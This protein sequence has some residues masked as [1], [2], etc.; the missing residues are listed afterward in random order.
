[1]KRRILALFLAFTLFLCAIPAAFAADY[2]PEAQY[3]ILLELDE[4]IRE[5]GLESSEEDEPLERALTRHLK[6]IPGES[7]LIQALA[8]DPTLFET[9]M[10]TM[11]SGYDEHTMYLPAGTYSAA[12]DPDT[13]YVGI[14]VTIQAHPQGVLVTDVNLLGSAAKAGIQM[15]D[16][17]TKADGQ[18]LAGMDVDAA[19]QLLRGEAGTTVS[20]TILRDG[21]EQSFL[22]E[23]T[24]LVQL[25]YSGAPIQEDIFYMK[26]SRIS[27]DGSYL[28]FRM[29]LA[30]MVRDGYDCLILDLRDNPG[31]SL[32]LAFSIATDLMPESGAFFRI[33]YRDPHGKEELTQ[34]YIIAEGDGFDV[35]YIFIL[36]NGNSA[37]AS[38]I[39]TAGLRDKEGAVVIGETTYGKGRAQQ[40]YVL[41]NDAGI[42]LTTMM[43][44][45]LEGEDYEG[46]GL[47]PDV[48]VHNTVLKGENAITVPTDVALAPYSCS[49]NGEALNRALVSLGL[50]EELPEKP[51]QVGEE[52]ME[53]L[54]LL[55]TSYQLS[56]T[57][58]GAGIPTLML[59]NLLLEYQLQGRYVQDLQLETAIDLAQEALSAQ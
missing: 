41:E 37:S 46:I 9:L 26:W 30:Q 20:V 50:L 33:V 25:S 55:Q 44:L 48:E 5:E 49:D 40:H 7:A 21:K 13:N 23:R 54:D 52:T 56:D 47:T 27:D 57:T 10:A 59:V 36:V 6:K 28:L 58:P 24:A 12:F 11:L 38:E 34:K 8:D 22:L 16:V 14:G 18:I 32:D 31:G 2:T 17:I 15:G 45:P 29:Q 43:L 3:Q 4:L 53:A 35:P 1:M 42:V 39:I 51:Y 19:S